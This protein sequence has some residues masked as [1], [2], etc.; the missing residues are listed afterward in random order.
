M[1]RPIAN[2]EARRAGILAQAVTRA[3]RALGLS[4]KA[5]AAAL[6]VSEATVSRLARGRAIDP[7]TKEGELALLVI[8]LF[9]SLDSLV[10]GDAAKTRDWMRAHNLHLRGVPAELIASVSGLVHVVEYLDALRGKS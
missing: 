9:R 6:G 2:T 1:G 8:R 3:A 4:Q 5:V 10:G 7:E